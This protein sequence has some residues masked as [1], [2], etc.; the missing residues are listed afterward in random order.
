MFPDILMRNCRLQVLFF[1]EQGLEAKKRRL[2]DFALCGERPALHGAGP[3]PPFKKGGRKL[4]DMGGRIGQV[5][6][7]FFAN[8]SEI[9]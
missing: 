5:E 1:V 6:E 7:E 8:F 9:T 2:G 4:S 3:V